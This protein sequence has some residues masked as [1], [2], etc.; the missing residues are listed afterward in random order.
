[1]DFPAAQTDHY[2]VA[3]FFQLQ[4]VFDQ[5]GMILGHQDRVLVT[6][7]IG[8]MEHED[9]QSVGFDPLAAV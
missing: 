4:R 3:D 9:M 5:I 8:R 6:E 2:F 1:M 7:E